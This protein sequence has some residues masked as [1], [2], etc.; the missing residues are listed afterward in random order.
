M[1][2]KFRVIICRSRAPR[3]DG[4]CEEV[5]CKLVHPTE[6]SISRELSH[7]IVL[8]FAIHSCDCIFV[9]FIVVRLPRKITVRCHLQV[10]NC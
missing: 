2:N 8:T 7:L 9:G 3:I 10:G 1:L 4:Y 6:I 5:R